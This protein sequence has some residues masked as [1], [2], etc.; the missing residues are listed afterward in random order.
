MRSA[1]AVKTSR[2]LEKVP[3]E[4]APTTV[5]VGRPVGARTAS[6]KARRILFYVVNGSGSDDAVWLDAWRNEAK[7]VANNYGGVIQI[8]I[9]G[10][11]YDHYSRSRLLLNIGRDVIRDEVVGQYEGASN[12]EKE[13]DEFS[14][15]G[16]SNGTKVIAEIEEWLRDNIGKIVML[17]GICTNS[18]IIKL[19]RNRRTK[20]KRDILLVCGIKDFVPRIASWAAP[21][22]YQDTGQRG[23]VAGWVKPRF[24][25][26][27]HS[28]CLDVRYFR[29]FIV[30]FL[31]GVEMER[32]SDRQELPL[33]LV[34]FAGAL[35]IIARIVRVA[36][37]RVVCAINKIHRNRKTVKVSLFAIVLILV[38]M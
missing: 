17:S 19:Y 16:Y 32:G 22:V 14:I 30:P 26:Y 12:D 38:V 24:H 2:L 18:D 9:F 6:D 25:Q 28:M 33:K 13:F 35:G 23:S 15:G 34:L 8:E 11:I 7:A 27:G 29:E 20:K 10:L 36:R 37:E 31:I 21:L 1:T 5:S 4:F 3:T